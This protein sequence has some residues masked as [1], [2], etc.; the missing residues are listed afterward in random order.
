[1]CPA[2]I[3]K[4]I[5]ARGVHCAMVSQPAPV[6]CTEQPSR[7]S[8]NGGATT[9]VIST[10]AVMGRRLHVAA[11]ARLFALAN[12]PLK[13]LVKLRAVMLRIGREQGGAY[14]AM[15]DWALAHQLGLL[16]CDL[17]GLLASQIF[18]RLASQA[19]DEWVTATTA[20]IA[21]SERRCHYFII[22]LSNP[23]R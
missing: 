1:M 23:G 21:E 14:R 16:S 4:P 3:G 20:K 8:T 19:V 6:P 11:P 9:R 12:V 2:A 15:P 5:A 10:P 13:I 18:Q 22:S 17:T 7:A